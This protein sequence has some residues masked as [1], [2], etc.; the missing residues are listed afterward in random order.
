MEGSN[1]TIAIAFAAG[2]LSFLTPCVLPLVPGYLSMISG[3]SVEHL[4]GEGGSRAKARRAVIFNSLAFNVGVSIIFILLGATAG[5]VGTVLFTRPWVRWVGGLV[6]VLF[7]LQM[8][9]V[10]KIGALYKDT[11]KFSED[12]PRGPFGA[13]LLGV[14]FAAGWTPCIG[15]ILGGIIGLAA[16]SGGWRNGLILSAFYAAG[17]VIPFLVAGLIL[18]QFLGFYGKFRRHL[19]KVEVASGVL[20]IFI[21]ALVAFNLLPKLA[22]ALAGW[23]PNAENLVRT[24][25]VPPQPP[26]ANAPGALPAPATNASYKPAP[27]VELKTLDGRPFRLSEY[28]GRVVLLNFWATWCVPCRAEIPALSELNRELGPRGFEVIGVTTHDSPEL[29]REYQQDIKMDYTVA[30]GGDSVATDYAVG[31]LPTTFL[32][33]RQGRVRQTIIGE[34]TRAYFESALAPLLDEQ[35]P[36]Q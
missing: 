33:D 4:K 30:F 20:L 24:E 2:L 16:T 13:M 18:N 15:P 32:I 1:I 7:G 28:R 3:V 19:H 35:P 12:K 5:W 36:T 34:K 6:I 17:L 29:V 9:G 26:A 27:D 10:L 11:R 14:A 25:P 23:M 8:M 21:G 22:S 31:V